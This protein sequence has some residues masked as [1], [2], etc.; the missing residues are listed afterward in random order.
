MLLLWSWS[1]AWGCFA[2]GQLCCQA[3][4]AHNSLHSIIY[5][6]NNNIAPVKGFKKSLSESHHP[7]STAALIFLSC[8]SLCPYVFSAHFHTLVIGMERT[9]RILLR[10]LGAGPCA[11]LP[12]IMLLP[13]DIYPVSPDCWAVYFYILI[14][15]I[16]HQKIKC[17]LSFFIF[18][19]RILQGKP[20]G[21]IRGRAL[22]CY[23]FATCL[24]QLTLLQKSHCGAHGSLLIT[25]GWAL[26]STVSH[27]MLTFPLF[28]RHDL[29]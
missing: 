19:N 22:T 25:I 9:L 3:L 24:H 14:I 29:I 12:V 18:V 4:Q 1:L 26:W 10:S 7:S 13:V 23:C 28:L 17:L 21:V 20:S 11:T 27:A 2:L 16:L 6:K 15:I 8:S 5:C